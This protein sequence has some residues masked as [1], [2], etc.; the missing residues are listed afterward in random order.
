YFHNGE[1]VEIRNPAD[2]R[3]FGIAVIFQEFSLVPYL[4][5]AQNIFLGREFPSRIP[6]LMDRRRLYREAQKVLD[7]IGLDVDPRT[8][9]HALGVAQQQMV[10]IGKALSQDARI[11]VMDEPTAA[12]SDRE[13]ER[14]FEVMRQLQAKGV[15]IVY[16]SH[17]MAEVFAL[18]DRITV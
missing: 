6:G 1:R 13:T 7:L 17:R 15:A 4:D 16:I 10:E 18:G 11:L 5:V 3:R 12:L 14:L 2:A 9:V 8:K